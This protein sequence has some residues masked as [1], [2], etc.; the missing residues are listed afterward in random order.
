[1]SITGGLIAFGV[2][3]VFNESADH[4][5]NVIESRLTDHNH[6]LS[7]A[8]DRAWEAV[9]LALAGDGL[10]NRILD[11]F[12]DADMRGVRDQINKFIDNTPTGLAPLG[13]RLRLLLPQG[14]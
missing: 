14:S 5:I 3:Y 1:M 2:R 4:I 12:R 7:K 6:A 10:F 13:R 11:V 8:N 9:G